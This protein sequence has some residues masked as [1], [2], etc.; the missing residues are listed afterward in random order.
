MPVMLRSCPFENFIETLHW[1]VEAIKLARPYVI[2]SDSRYLV[3][4]IV[5]RN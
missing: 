2:F 1:V 4:Y 5:F 3:M